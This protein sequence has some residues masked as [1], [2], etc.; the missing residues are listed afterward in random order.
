[1]LVVRVGNGKYINADRMTYVEPGHKG[2]LVVH[3]DVGG[4]DIA[5]P[6]CRVKLEQQ[7]A[8]QFAR[9]LDH[10]NEGV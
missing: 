10:R 5:G 8:E 4:G 2:T 9:W 7:E 1:M 6:A 3:F